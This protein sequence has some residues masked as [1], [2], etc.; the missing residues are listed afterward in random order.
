M[1]EEKLSFEES[2]TVDIVNQTFS[3]INPFANP[4]IPIETFEPLPITEYEKDMLKGTIDTTQLLEQEKNEYLI[5]QDAIKVRRDKIKVVAMY[6]IGKHILSD[7]Y[8]L[9]GL[10]KENFYKEVVKYREF[11]DELLDAEFNNACNNGLFD[12]DFRYDLIRVRPIA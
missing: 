5:R 7:P 1:S 9:R 8:Y 10:D 6:R 2:K 4:F 12:N 11:S 3:D